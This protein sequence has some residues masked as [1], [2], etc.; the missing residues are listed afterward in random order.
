FSEA[1]AVQPWQA[2][3][4]GAGDPQEVRAY[5]VSASFFGLLGIPPAEGRAL[6]DCDADQ[7]RHPVVI[8]Y[9]FWRERMGGELPVVGQ[10]LELNGI[11]HTVIGLMPRELDYPM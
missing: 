9:G 2:T 11:N 8:S 3:R 7:E 6:T 5:Q 1:A 4:T 10:T